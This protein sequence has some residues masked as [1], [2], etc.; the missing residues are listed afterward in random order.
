MLKAIFGDQ[1]RLTVNLTV[2]TLLAEQTSK[3]DNGLHMPLM[4]KWE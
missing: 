1:V 3:C 2:E 4:I